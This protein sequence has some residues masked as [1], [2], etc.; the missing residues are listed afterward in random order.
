MHPTMMYF[1]I[2]LTFRRS[3]IALEPYRRYNKVK[4]KSDGTISEFCI[5][6]ISREAEV[7]D[8]HARVCANGSSRR[9]RRWLS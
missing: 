6:R 5:P 8:R 7:V 2:F 1:F 3:I 4:L 9:R